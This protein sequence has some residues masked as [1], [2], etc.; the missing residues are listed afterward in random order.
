ML[1]QERRKVYARLGMSKQ[2]WRPCLQQS[3]D[4]IPIGLEEG[5]GTDAERS[6]RLMH[7]WVQKYSW[8]L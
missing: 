4:L 7:V 6:Q 5:V 8:A 3:W 1:L 2:N